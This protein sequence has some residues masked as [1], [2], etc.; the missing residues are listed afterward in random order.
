MTTPHAPCRLVASIDLA[1][2]VAEGPDAG[3]FLEGQLGRSLPALDAPQG[4]LA[5]WHDAKGRVQGLFRVFRPADERFW[6]TTPRR[7]AAGVVADLGRFVLRS[8][9]AL[10]VDAG[11]IDCVALLGDCADVLSEP[12]A[13]NDLLTARLGTGLVI[14]VGANAALRQLLASLPTAAA[15]DV[16]LAEIRL[17]LPSV[18]AQLRGEFLPQMLDLDRLGA[19]EFDKGCYPGQEIIARSQHRG[20]I[21]RRLAHFRCAS[22]THTPAAGDRI[23]DRDGNRVGRTVRAALTADGSELLAVVELAAMKRQLSLEGPGTR[24][25]EPA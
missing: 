25:L 16:E 5:A 7:A 4:A 23:V 11:D 8:Q 21:K 22:G 13:Y 14:G 17:G 24:T 19:I 18:D 20:T 6:L 9:V 12:P 2:I 3:V 10:D 15:A 1:V